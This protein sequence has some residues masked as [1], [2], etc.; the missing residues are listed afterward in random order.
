M[1]Q[2]T[3]RLFMACLFSAFCF[4]VQ[5][6]TGSLKGKVTEETGTPVSGATVKF[7]DRNTGV[8][9]RDDGTF[10]I[11]STG[12]GVLVVSALG[13]ADKEIT[14]N[15]EETLDVVLSKTTQQ[16][17]DVVV[18]ALGVKREKRNLT[19]STQEVK[20]DELLRAKEPNV[21]N[22]LAGKVAGVQITSSSGTPGSSS[23]I[24]IRGAS[25]FF[26]DNQALIILDGVPINN[27]ETGNLNSGP[28]TNRLSDIDPSII[29]NINVLKGAAATAL[30]GS[31]GARGVVMITTKNG[32]E[33][34]KPTL[35]FSQD[36]SFEKPLLP[37]IQTKYGQGERGVY[38][39]G[40]DQKTSAVWGPL[41]DTLKIDGKP[42]QRYNQADLFFKTGITSN[43]TVSVSGGGNASSYFMSYSYLDQKGTTPKTDYKRHSIFTKYTTK[44]YKN[45]TSTFQFNYV[46]SHNNRLP[47]GYTLE[48][49]IWTVLTA[50]YTWNPLPYLNEDGTQRVFRYSRN[51]PYWVV[52]NIYNK[53]DVNRFVPVMTV[54]YTPFKWLTL[55]ERVGADIYS[56][57]DK[58]RESPGSIATPAG[59]II[60][61]NINFRQFNHDFMVNATKEFGKFN[62]NLLLGNN[63]YS[64][65]SQYYDQTGLGLSVQ[66]FDNIGIASTITTSEAYYRTR[67]VG[68]YAQANVDYNRL[69][70]LSLTGR[71]DGSSVLSRDNSFYPYGSAAASFIFSEL[72][73]EDMKR[74]INLAKLRVSYA[75]VG[76]DGVGA[77]SLATPYERATIGNISFP[78]NGQNGFL[79]SGTLGNQNLKNE[80]IGEFE[81]GLETRLFN[82]RVGVEA[83]YFNKKTTNGLIPG[84]SIAPSTGFTG[85][86]VN[87]AEM[88]NKGIEVLLNVS[89]VRAKKFSWDVTFNFTKINNKVLSIYKD[90]TQLGNGFTQ[91][92]VDQ[93]YGVK[94]GGKYARAE[95]GQLLVDATG[96]PFRE[97]E[98]GMIGNITPD[99]LAGLNNTFRYG[100]LSLSFFFDMKK[101]GDIEN[102]V[103]GYGYFYGTPK[104][105]ENREDRII[106]GIKASDGKPNDI[107]VTAQDY[108]RRING[109]TEAVIQDGTYI[110]LRNVNLSY[111]FNSSLLSK[112]PFK[113][114][115]L[116]V[117]GRNL[118]IY[119]PHFTGADPEV[120]S[121]G[122]SNGSQGIYSF[123]TPTSRSVNFSLKLTF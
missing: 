39:N 45:L 72:L 12:K 71:Y 111:D 89:P 4:V 88:E 82:N 8:I 20:G 31:A 113:S 118:W 70:V 59:R 11:A 38:F 96:L 116:S 6:Q 80:K 18:T 54:N 14:I 122:S 53:A 10:S 47:E 29:E 98:D 21:V 90:M 78:F 34:R 73:P 60:Q 51:N 48:S 46:S 76:N 65:Y 64:V 50:P 107:T 92:I 33:N 36:F 85:T 67:K 55:T 28:G 44:I 1:K 91:I 43:S 24:V 16:L 19:Y 25:S 106:A 35:S 22:A 41:I 27:D 68:F 101:G 74:S 37:E 84:V 49:P 30:Y 103:D 56:E 119:S 63:L 23:R 108:Y 3:P 83:S 117:T 115:T 52:D 2:R 87:S 58:Y 66:D 93:P 109:I 99:W 15:G 102:N 79:M 61:R 100:P 69:L 17:I 112:T 121:F 97:V 40:E 7:K 81:I 9:T 123:G 13:Y 57:Q 86:T 42:A 110:K 77:Y 95:D 94:W 26:G 75:V 105:T 5:A 114:A 120:S 104:V 32:G 62:V